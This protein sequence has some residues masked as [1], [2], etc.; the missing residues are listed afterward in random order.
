MTSAG[1]TVAAF[2]GL[3]S[4]LDRPAAQLRAALERLGRLPRSELEAVSG[5]YGNPPMGPQDQP[6]YVNA[7]A[8]LRTALSPR[9]LLEACQGI[10]RDQG[11]VRGADR[12]GPRTIDLD[13]LL[14]GEAIVEEPGL[15]VPHPGIAERPFVLLPLAELAPDLRVP[16]AGDVARLLEAVDTSALERLPEPDCRDAAAVAGQRA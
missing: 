1:G 4:N 3:G 15:H 2:I 8:R 5:F 7:V 16:G 11:R 13:V 12:W 9:A 14:Y 10:E 6:D